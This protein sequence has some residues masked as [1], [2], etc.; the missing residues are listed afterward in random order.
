M[1]QAHP[2]PDTIRQALAHAADPE[3]APKMQAYMK[4]D[5]PYRGVDAKGQRTIFRAAWKEFPV[6][7]FQEYSAVVRDLW[8]HAAYRE[9]R[10]AAQ[11]TAKRFRKFHLMEALPL[12]RHMIET[13]AWW[14]HVDM[15][16]AD[17]I[18]ALLGSFP[19]QMTPILYEW[20]ED[21]H[22]WIRRAAILSQLRFKEKTDAAML[23]AFCDRCLEETTFWMRKAIGWALRQHSKTDPD[24]VRGFIAAHRERMAGLTF[25]EASKY[26]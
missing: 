7:T 5:M 22:L 24:P 15:I 4:S 1:S 16:S 23:F 6:N 14:D 18:G 10:Y 8:D 11:E 17:L 20:I 26:V 25:R 19:D 13:G 12:Y 3:R 2:L 9:E 21:D